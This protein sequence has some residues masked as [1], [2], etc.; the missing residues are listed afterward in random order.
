MA[1][2]LTDPPEWLAAQLR[3]CRDNPR[4]LRPTAVAVATE[5]YGSAHRWQEVLPHVRAHVGVPE[6]TP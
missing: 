6:G 4:L 1:E 5:V 3:R 2:L